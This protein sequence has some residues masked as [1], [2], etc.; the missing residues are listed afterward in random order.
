M[1]PDH[2]DHHDP[3][4]SPRT[5]ST[6]QRVASVLGVVAG[7]LFIATFVLG[8]VREGDAHAWLL[9]LGVVFLLFPVLMKRLLS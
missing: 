8:L 7:L 2:E 6:M 4:L 3:D 1:I 9:G 5:A